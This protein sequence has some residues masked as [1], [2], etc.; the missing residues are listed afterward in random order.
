MVVDS[1]LLRVSY[2]GALA[3]HDL[4]TGRL[5]ASRPVASPQVSRPAYGG[6]S[7][8][9]VAVGGEVEVF[10]LSAGAERSLIDTSETIAC[11]AHAWGTWWIIPTLTGRVLALKRSRHAVEWSLTFRDPISF[12]PATSANYLALIDDHGRMVVYERGKP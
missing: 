5:R 11:G 12:A 3:E 8:A 4:R 10:D 7:L 6:G 9:T 2:E 1:L